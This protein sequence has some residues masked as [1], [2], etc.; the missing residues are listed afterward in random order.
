MQVA[1]RW[2][3]RVAKSDTVSDLTFKDALRLLADAGDA[4][5]EAEPLWGPD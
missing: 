4:E 5:A 1:R 2:D 3:E